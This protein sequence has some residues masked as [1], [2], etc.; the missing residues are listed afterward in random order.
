MKIQQISR[1]RLGDQGKDAGYQI[2]GASAQVDSAMESEFTGM[3]TTLELGN[4]PGTMLPYILDGGYNMDGN[5]FYLTQIYA[6]KDFKSRPT[7]YVHGLIFDQEQMADC[8]NDPG[9]FFRFRRE[10]S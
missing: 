9:D 6:E 5:R 4:E 8:F 1:F 2:S 3:Y 10:F 7:P